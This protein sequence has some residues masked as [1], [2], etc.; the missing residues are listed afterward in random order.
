MFKKKLASI[1]GETGRPDTQLRSLQ[2]F[3][4]FCSTISP[5]RQRDEMELAHR[6]S[7]A[8]E[9]AID[10]PRFCEVCGEQVSFHLD[11]MYSDGVTLNFR[12]QLVCPKCRLNNRQRYIVSTVLSAYVPGQSVYLYEQITAAFKAMESHLGARNV[13]GSEYIADGLRSGTKVNGILHEDAEHLSFADASFD[14][15][16][17]CDVFEHVNNYE[18]CFGEAARVLKPGGKLYLSIPFY[19]DR[20]ENHR[21]AGI[22]GGRL[23]HYD[24]PIYHGNPMKDE[25]SLVFW[26]YGWGILDDL[27]RAGFCDAFMAPY[28]SKEYGY[29]GGIPF[30][31][32]AS[33]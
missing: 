21:R 20:Q 9:K 22:E 14:M 4:S 8:A 11:F 24:A 7:C 13:T 16:V 12:E 25:G 32:V 5:D 23:V 28:Y 29:I 30:L 6:C 1:N 26:D 18:N 15:I 10:V 2:E 31:F 19:V 27:K 33:K 3:S 17:S